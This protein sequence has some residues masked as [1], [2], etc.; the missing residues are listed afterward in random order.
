MNQNQN[1]NNYTMDFLNEDLMTYAELRNFIKSII[2]HN[3]ANLIASKIIKYCF[4]NQSKLY[5]LQKTISYY[6][7]DNDVKREI[8][9]IVSNLINQSFS[10]LTEDEQENLNDCYKTQTL[11]IFKNS[12]I[13]LFY[14][15]LEIM[16]SKRNMQFDI[17]KREMHFRNGYMDFNDLVFK[18]RQ[19]NTHFITK[20]IDRDYVKSTT[21]Q[22]EC[23]LSFVNPIYP[24]KKDLACILFELGSAITGES[25]KDQTLLFLLGKGTSGKTTTMNITAESITI[26]FKS[27]K[28]DTFSTNNP[29]RDKII[30]TYIYEPQIRVTVVNEMDDKRVDVPLIKQVVEGKLETTKLYEDGSKDVTHMSKIFF[31]SNTFPNIQI[32]TATV[33]RINSYTTTSEFTHDLSKV[34]HNKRVYL[35][36]DNLLDKIKEMDLLNAWFDILAEYANKWLQGS[37]P[38]FTE[39]FK[40]AK[41]AIVNSNDIVQDFIDSKLIITNDQYDTIGKNIM[42]DCFIKMY[43][44]K[45]LTVLQVIASLTDRNIKYNSSARCAEMRGCFVGV[46]FK[47]DDTIDFEAFQQGVCVSSEPKEQSICEALNKRIQVLESKHKNELAKQKDQIDELNQILS[48]YKNQITAVVQ[49]I[50]K[51]T[52]EQRYANLLTTHRKLHKKIE[53]D[54]I[55][56]DD[57]IFSELF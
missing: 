41:D 25:I 15:Q 35:R 20:F 43:P 14:A 7:S 28:N 39:A 21:E 16:I 56:L 23:I 50:I 42:R 32:E 31:T 6:R 27:L 18:Q 17:N 48:N 46:K 38:Q 53:I 1:Q 11:A 3:K 49:P 29:K 8:I 44:D 24:N 33:R 9:S 12:T 2:P 51:L 13:E 52:S 45:H 54:N 19:L 47:N 40:N 55:Q 4:I 36:D 30:N 10:N 34:D 5:L 26:Y 57:D 37:R 22:Q